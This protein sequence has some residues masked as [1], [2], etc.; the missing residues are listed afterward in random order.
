M[1]IQLDTKD[2]GDDTPIHR[3][4][5]A[6][7]HKEISANLCAFFVYLCVTGFLRS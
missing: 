4:V 1:Q 6:K 2:L 3:D 5:N 7:F